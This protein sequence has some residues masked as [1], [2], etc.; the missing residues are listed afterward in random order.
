MAFVIKPSRNPVIQAAWA[1]LEKQRRA[2][3]KAAKVPVQEEVT[4]APAKKAAAKKA[5][6]KK[7][8]RK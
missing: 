8:A 1:G 4:K 2:E 6:A 7:G 3:K 5:A